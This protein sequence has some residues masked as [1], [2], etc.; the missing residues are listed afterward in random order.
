MYNFVTSKEII[1]KFKKSKYFTQNLGYSLSIAK[2]SGRQFSIND[3]DKFVKFFFEKYRI[4]IMSEGNI[5]SINFFTNY[6][7]KDDTIAVFNNN[8]DFIF[9]HDEQ[10]LLSEGVDSYIGS[11]IKNIE[12][13]YQKELEIA[14]LEKEKE[15]KIIYGDAA[16]LTENPGQVSWAD[17]QAYY[18]VKKNM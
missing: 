4:T 6:Y 16:K 10:K 7:I 9:T 2:D 1:Q 13:N 14:K 15:N 17:I 8:K 18:K 11:F 3:K 12:V 5:G